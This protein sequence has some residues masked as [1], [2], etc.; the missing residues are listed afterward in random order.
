MFKYAGVGIAIGIVM[1]ILGVSLTDVTELA[2]VAKNRTE[3]FVDDAIPVSVKIDRMEVIRDQMDAMVKEQV[4]SPDSI[5][6]V[7]LTTI[8]PSCDSNLIL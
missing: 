7:V 4:M 3:D 8:R 6:N 1:S 2:A 5:R